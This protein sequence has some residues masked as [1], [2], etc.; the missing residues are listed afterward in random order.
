ML[1]EV[2]GK[3]S[4]FPGCSLAT[5][6]KENN[7]SLIDFFKQAGIDLVEIEDW[8]CCGSS[9]A[10][11]I[12]SDLAD[13]LAA[14]NLS[15]APSDRPL[16][17][18]CPSCFLRLKHCQL[19]LRKDEAARQQYESRFGRAI[20]PELEILHFFEILDRLDLKQISRQS[21]G[22]LR[23]LRCAPY[24]GCMSARPPEMKDEKTYRGLMEEILRNLGAE[25]VS[26][27]YASRCCGT[28]LSVVRPD[29]VT[30]MVNKILSDAL[31]CHADCIVT[32]CAMCHMNLE[33]RC[34]LRHPIPILHFSEL[35][36]MANPRARK[37]AWFQRHL[38]DPRPML[39]T[40]QLI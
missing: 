30:G 9:S 39:E 29:M 12:D 22:G 37:A 27:A 26:W 17:V 2:K 1:N 8:N 10:H 19:K 6:A 36:A 15:L 11:S 23:G 33:I 21:L 7:E 24:Y 3:Y 40:R 4:Y 38:I 32:A 14:R 25:P 16:A 31:A 5:S 28:F 35:L 18:A 34:S 20:D 13:L